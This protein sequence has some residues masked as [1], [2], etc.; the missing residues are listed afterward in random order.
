MR[1][2]TALNLVTK[3]GI[4]VNVSRAWYGGHS[5]NQTDL[6]GIANRRRHLGT[7]VPIFLL[8]LYESNINMIDAFIYHSY[9]VYYSAD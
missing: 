1:I 5:R 3:E 7:C 8:P 4:T 6:T 2:R 9:H